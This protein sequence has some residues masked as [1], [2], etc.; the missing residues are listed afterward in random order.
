MSIDDDGFDVTFMNRW[1]R[2]TLPDTW[3]WLIVGA[4]PVFAWGMLAGIGYIV[5]GGFEQGLKAEEVIGFAIAA[6]LIPA[7]VM[8]VL[9]QLTVIGP[10]GRE[11]GLKYFAVL[12]AVAAVASA[13]GAGLVGRPIRAIEMT[14]NESLSALGKQLRADGDAFQGEMETVGFNRIQNPVNLARDVTE[15]RAIIRKSSEISARYEALAE[16]RIVTARA[17]LA[18]GPRGAIVKR[19]ALQRFDASL[20]AT[21]ARQNTIWRFQVD[22]LT[23][24]TAMTDLLVKRRGTWIIQDGKLAFMRQSDITDMRSRLYRIAEMRNSQ[25]NAINGIPTIWRSNRPGR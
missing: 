20:D 9:L 2:R 8:G 22:I 10:S 23:E 25:A 5:A 24:M 19:G 1:S 12:L 13:A 7:V 3:P 17:R 18:K 15:S 6:L 14:A 16:T 11:V 21:R 4:G